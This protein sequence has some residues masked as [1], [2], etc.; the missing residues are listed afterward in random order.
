MRSDDD[1]A[2]PDTLSTVGN[3]IRYGGQNFALLEEKIIQAGYWN[4]QISPHQ[5]LSLRDWVERILNI[6]FIRNDAAHRANVTRKQFHLLREQ[7]FGSPR[8]G[9]GVLSGLLLVWQVPIAPASE[10]PGSRPLP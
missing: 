3:S 5:I 6:S 10:T 1:R 4:E 2:L 8:N 9:I 7:Y